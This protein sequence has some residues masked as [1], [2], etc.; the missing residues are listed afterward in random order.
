MS[1]VDSLVG[2][3]LDHPGETA[4]SMTARCVR[5]FEVVQGAPLPGAGTAD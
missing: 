1:V 3:W 4:A 2:W 5:L